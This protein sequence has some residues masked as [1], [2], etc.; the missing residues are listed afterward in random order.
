M[1]RHQSSAIAA[2]FNPVNHVKRRTQD[3]SS[4]ILGQSYQYLDLTGGGAQEDDLR[5]F[6]G[7]FVES[8]PQFAFPA[9]LQ[10]VQR[11]QDVSTEV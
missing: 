10:P 6:L 4:E 1:N 3:N 7:E 8:L 5:A 11:L 9:G 2:K